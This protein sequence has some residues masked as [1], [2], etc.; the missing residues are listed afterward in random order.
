MYPDCD[1]IRILLNFLGNVQNLEHPA[2]PWSKMDFD[3]LAP[4]GLQD[5]DVGGGQ[6]TPRPICLADRLRTVSV[7]FSMLSKSSTTLVRATF[8]G[9]KAIADFLVVD[10]IH[11][12]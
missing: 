9:A 1:Q 6:S 2:P 8:V 3:G 10:A 11:E 7:I 5:F 12:Q 4:V